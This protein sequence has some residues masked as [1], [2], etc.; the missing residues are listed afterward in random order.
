LSRATAAARR[1]SWRPLTERRAEANEK[2]RTSVRAFLLVVEWRKE[3]R[4]KPSRPALGARFNSCCQYDL[5]DVLPG[6][7]QFVC[8]G[9]FLKREGLVDHRLD[10][11][12]VHQRPYLF[13]Q[14]SGDRGLERVRARTQ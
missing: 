9:R 4:A 1:W 8:P 11:A 14:L 13:T 7:H 10:L 2:A 12:G 5:A 6:F 3:S